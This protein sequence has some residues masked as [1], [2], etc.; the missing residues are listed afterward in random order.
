MTGFYDFEVFKYDWLA[1]FI[2]ERDEH[3]IVWNDPA[4]L[5][6]ALERF[7]CLVGFNNYSYDD[8][9]LTAIM[10]GYNNYEIYTLSNTIVNGG[11]IPA[12]IRSKARKLTTLD[13]KQELAPNLSLKEIEANLG[14]N[15]I[16]TPIS[17]NLDRPLTD[18]EFYEV[19]KYCAHD[20]ETTKRV[21]SL[22]Q[23]YFES[24]FDICREFKLDKLD[25]RKTRANLASKVLKCDKNRLPEGVL[26]NKD[27]LDIRFVEELRT[28]N[29][30]LTIL[31]FYN[32]IKAK[33][34]N[35]TDY[36]ELEKESL[37]IDLCG[38]EHTFAFGGLHGAKEN[39]KYEGNMLNVD[40]GSYYPS[41]MINFGFMSRASEHPD[42]YKNLYD[43]RM[44]YKAKKDNK[45]QIYKILLNSTFGALKSE[46]ND[47]FDPVMSNDICVNGQLILTDLIMSLR[48]CSELIQSNTDGIL[49]KYKDKDLETIKEKCA[50]WELNY[51][52]KLDYE[53]VTKI[54]QR[55]VNNYILK[56]ADGKIKGKGIF[57]NFDGGNFEKN[58]MT[59]VDIVLKEYYINGKDIRETITQMIEKNN[60]TPLQQIA[61][62]GGTYDLMEH[63]GQEVQKVNRIFATWDNN[64]GAINKVKNKDGVK[65]Y[66]KIANSS[67]KCYINNDVIENTDTKLIDIDYYVRLVEKN[68]FIDENYKLF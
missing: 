46:F 52:L 37:K 18:D 29:I 66:T 16:E 3:L 9:I 2:N 45:Q 10:S 39:F 24:K 48:G 17:F 41:L 30:P 67:D 55:D 5:K 27:R 57:A 28:E 61:K 11:N 58:N 53:Y 64:Y 38:V 7:D 13:T 49:I 50:E 36:R 33:F 63:N 20:V 34:K 59:V 6:K 25:V 15:I 21:F 19:V 8:L 62:M 51:N 43:T 26:E 40:V 65:K 31:N 44:E 56:T 60:V 12:D 54:V 42:L 47:L 1:V 22:R 14:L 23:D 35:G 32:N 4:I 68:K